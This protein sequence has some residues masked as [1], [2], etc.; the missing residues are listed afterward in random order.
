MI[1]KTFLIIAAVLV[2]FG[3]FSYVQNNAL[4]VTEIKVRSDEI[5][6]AFQGYTIVHLSD[7]HSKEFGDE[8]KT[9][10]EKVRDLK[11]DVIFMTGDMIDAN[12]YNEQATIDV[13]KQLSP[14]Y[15]I[16]F[17]TGNHEAASGRFESFEKELQTHN[18]EILRNEY[19]KLTKDNQYIYVLGID[20]PMFQAG[21][22]DEVNVVRNGIKAAKEG[23]DPNGF[24]MLLS[25][26]P[27]HFPAYIEANV[28]LVFSGHAH[29]GQ[30]RLPFIG[31]LVA[32][33]QGLFPEYTAGEY[34]EDNTSMVVSR[35]LGNSIIPQRICN[36]PEIVVVELQ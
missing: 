22:E 3:I 23:T 7:L 34:K 33:G 12:R 20:D 19:A 26:R 31:G 10:V 36:R 28:D 15:P 1:K 17:V 14:H 9:L 11:P 6:E 4:S 29:G 16:Y 2:F 13:V 24:H 21:T 18:V 35:G 25:H 5:P 32:P 27:E 30:V 8:Q